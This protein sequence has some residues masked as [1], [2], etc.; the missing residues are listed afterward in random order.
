ML[1]PTPHSGT[2]AAAVLLRKPLY[3]AANVVNS[4]TLGDSFSKYIVRKISKYRLD[5]FI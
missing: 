4:Q 5:F 1:L 3:A 2:L